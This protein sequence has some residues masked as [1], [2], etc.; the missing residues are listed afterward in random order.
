MRLD[1]EG[2]SRY[3]VKASASNESL[4]DCYPYTVGQLA[5][6]SQ[7]KAVTIRYYERQ[8]LMPSPPRSE[9]GYRIYSS[10]DLDRLLFIRRGRHLGFSLESIRE[11]LDLADR[12]NAPCA[13][14]DAKVAQQLAEVRERLER[15]RALETE[16][17]RLGSCCAGGG[18][19]EDCHII[20]A[21]SGHL[22]GAGVAIG[23]G[24][25]L[26]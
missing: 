11:L 8:G 13:E 19:V 10:A 4:V 25:S 23:E 5:Q 12:R 17:Q 20:E 14:V 22:R 21:L 18:A 3:K 15:L 7:I 1:H 24:S 2:Y 9:A 26:A 6:R 16:L